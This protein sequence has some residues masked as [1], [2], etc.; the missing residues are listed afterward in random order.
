MTELEEKIKH[1]A[2]AYY[3]GKEEIPDEEYDF[4]IARLRAE[5]PDSELLDDVAGEDTHV[6]GF[7]KGKHDLVTGTLVKCRDEQQFTEWIEKHKFGDFNVQQKMDGAG[8]ELKY[9]DG[10][11]FEA[12][13][14]GNGFQG[15]VITDN[16]MLING[17]KHEV[18]GFTGSIRGEV[19]MSHENFNKYFPDKK[20][21]RNT[22]A[23]VMKHIHGEDCDKLDFVAYEVYDKDGK[24]DNT[25]T[26]KMDFLSKN[27]F[28]TPEWFVTKDYDKIIAFRAAQ[29]AARAE[30]PYDIDGIVVKQ[31]RCMKDDL[32]RRTPLNN[33]AIKF[34]LVEAETTLRKIVWQLQGTIFSAVGIFDPV[35]LNGT[36]VRRA[37]LCNLH[38]MDKLGVEVGKKCII[39][40]AGEII[41]RLLEVL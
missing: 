7:E 31:E 32:K 9:K 38:K 30:L 29:A 16:A 24:V 10:R 27:G 15:D 19:L 17:I 25:E 23:G 40:K 11:L 34:N 14:R 35:D 5:Q 12:V 26:E 18:P 36:T 39:V 2:D 33:V 8:I 13:S 1:Y 3:D 22:A 6:D 20:N 28:S 37:T 21:C 41:P 4:L